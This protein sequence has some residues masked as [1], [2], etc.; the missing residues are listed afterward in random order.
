MKLKLEINLDNAAF[1]GYGEDYTESEMYNA[2][3]EIINRFHYRQL[4][5]LLMFHEPVVLK[6]CNGNSV[7]KIEIIK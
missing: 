3:E 6:D 5:K 4:E 1:A 2:V 7:G